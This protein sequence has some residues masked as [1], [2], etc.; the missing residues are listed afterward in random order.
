MLIIKKP[1]KKILKEVAKQLK[2]GAVV[3]Y[4]TDTAYAL[5]CDATNAKA[6][7]K[8]FKIKGRDKS[9]ALPMIVADMEMAKKF[10]FLS[11]PRRRESN[12]DWSAVNRFG[13]DPRFREGDKLMQLA[14]RHW[15]GPL[16]I[17]VKAKTPIAKSAL[18]KG[19][20]AVRV[21][22]SAIAQTLSKYLGR[23]IVAT[24]ANISYQPTCYSVRAV[25]RQFL[26]PSPCVAIAKRGE[27][28]VRGGGIYVLD[29]GA[30][31]RRQPSTIVKIN[32]DGMIEVLRKGPINILR[33]KR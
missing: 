4:P 26:S 31:P 2:R 15:P 6:V 29:T 33:A 5:G 1:N 22:D 32:N 9:K 27:G 8:I 19:T 20:A 10:F 11:F 28:G 14:N 13:L 7:A 18:S 16:S 3:V 25:L 12:R 30:L 17:I 21:P 24:S 23:P